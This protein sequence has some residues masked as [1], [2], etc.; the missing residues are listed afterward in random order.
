MSGRQVIIAPRRLERPNAFSLAPWSYDDHDRCPFCAG[1]EDQ[2]PQE[3][4]IYRPAVTAEAWSVRVVPNRY[5]A[6][7]MIGN[8]ANVQL[9]ESDN[10]PLHPV[11]E[12]DGCQEVIVESPR[13][14]LSF[15]ELSEEEATQVV[16]AYRDRQLAASRDRRLVAGL[17]FKNYG[18]RAG[19]SLSHIH[20]QFAGFAK[21]PATLRAEFAASERYAGRHQ[22]C[23]FCAIVTTESTSKKRIVLM[24]D[25]FVAFCPFASRLPYEVCIAPR[26]HSSRFEQLTD[27]DCGQ[28]ARCLADVLWRLETAVPNVSY[29]F[30]VHSAA[31]DSV[32]YDHYH[33]H[34]EL[35]PRAAS[36][37]GFEWGSGQLINPVSPEQAAG[38]LRAARSDGS[39][40]SVV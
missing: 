17:V 31:F 37:A 20:S 14:L 28:F 22:H 40:D 10:E 25:S 36:T 32:S 34:L 19:A 26:A 30:W 3:L 23:L 39:A 7:D 16:I 38:Q 6:L 8:A 27:D 11:D 29:N 5:P 15:T 13:H 2:T 18:P 21:I 33:W 1:R 35:V 4:A 24:N 9:Q 12:I